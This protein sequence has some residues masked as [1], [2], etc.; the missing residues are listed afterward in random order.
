MVFD[1][2][3]ARQSYKVAKGMPKS[4]AAHRSGVPVLTAFNAAVSASS[5]YEGIDEA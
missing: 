2:R 4:Y 1:C 3:P 5:V